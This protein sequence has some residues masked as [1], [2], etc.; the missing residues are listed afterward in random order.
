MNYS[1]IFIIWLIGAII[2]TYITFKYA[3]P[4][5][6]FKLINKYHLTLKEKLF[7][8][9]FWSFVICGYTFLSWF[10]ALIT[11]IIF[12]KNEA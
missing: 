9:I 12:Y 8:Y 1:V 4:I 2:S 6:T 3:K 7:P 10:G 5:E 11:Y